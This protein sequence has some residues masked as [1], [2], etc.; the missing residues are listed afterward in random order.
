MSEA[1]V[2]IEAYACSEH[3]DGP[4]FAAF[5]L[6]ESLIEELTT[7]SQLCADHGLSEV[8][9]LRGCMWGPGTIQDDLRLRSDELVVCGDE[10][11]F[12]ATPKYADYHVETRG[13]SIQKLLVDAKGWKFGDAPLMY[14][15]YPQE[16]WDELIAN[17]GGE[18]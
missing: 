12:R 3:G 15:E 7:L 2:F 17:E 8:R 14:G 13:L 16:E 18:G 5:K 6:T 1:S 9:C 4:A 10:F 11:W